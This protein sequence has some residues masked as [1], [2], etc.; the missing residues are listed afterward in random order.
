[1]LKKP[2]PL[3]TKEVESPTSGDE[4]LEDELELV[5]ERKENKKT[6]PVLLEGLF[7]E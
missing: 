3:V 2:L 7:H 5:E 6:R 1:M 4:A